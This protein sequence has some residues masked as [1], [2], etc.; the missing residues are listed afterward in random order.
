MS[1]AAVRLPRQADVSAR[2][3]RA[4]D[5]F[6]HRRRAWLRSPTSCRWAAR[7]E[8]DE[9]VPGRLCG[10]PKPSAAR[11]F[12]MECR[13]AFDYARQRH[14]MD[15]SRDGTASRS[16]HRRPPVRSRPS[17]QPLSARRTMPP[18]PKFALARNAETPFRDTPSRWGGRQGR[19]MEEPL[20]AQRAAQRNRALLAGMG[21]GAAVTSGAGGKWSRGR[22]WC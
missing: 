4:G 8:G 2:H 10:S 22:R 11:P 19:C 20:D 7:R 13:P 17:E 6:F 5:P 16:S 12:R 3:Q 9:Q 1:G 18:S 14:E 21:R 15:L